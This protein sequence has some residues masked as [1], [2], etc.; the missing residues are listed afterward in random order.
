MPEIATG[1]DWREFDLR[2]IN[3][4][5]YRTRRP[6]RF[7]GLGVA[8]GLAV[9]AIAVTAA[10]FGPIV[11]S[12]VALSPLGATYAI[13]LAI[14]LVSVGLMGSLYLA[15]SPGAHLIRVDQTGLRLT[16][17][18]TRVRELRWVDA[19]LRLKLLDFSSRGTDMTEYGSVYFLELRRGQW[20]ALS[21]QAFESIRETVKQQGLATTQYR[22][23]AGYG[24]PPVITC[25]H[26]RGTRLRLWFRK[27]LTTG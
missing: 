25:V 3:Q 16:Y 5:L 26:P 7:L 14:V 1:G 4:Q 2:S 8:V 23:I 21:A 9:I 18:N 19:H 24:I 27:R 10:R 6:G 11:S 22:G 13:V 17:S 12:L 15:L 20:T